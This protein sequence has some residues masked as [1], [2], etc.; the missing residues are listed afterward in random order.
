MLWAPMF[1]RAVFLNSHCTLEST[2]KLKKNTDAILYPRPIKLESLRG[3]SLQHIL[4]ELSLSGLRGCQGLRTILC[5][6]GIHR[7]VLWTI[8][9][10]GGGEEEEQKGGWGVNN[11]IKVR[12]WILVRTCLKKGRTISR[13][14]IGLRD[15]KR[16]SKMR[17][18]G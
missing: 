5:E 12:V 13:R 16:L 3:Y 6:E 11:E 18:F 8:P 2:R 15:T 17:A 14:S 10:R 9:P 7:T 4:K 1:S